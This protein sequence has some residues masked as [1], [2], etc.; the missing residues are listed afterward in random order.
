MICEI[1]LKF[2]Y[3]VEN[4]C[5]LKQQGGQIWRGGGSVPP[6][7]IYIYSRSDSSVVERSRLGPR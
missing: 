1:Q 3:C 6:S 2:P 4:V 5:F 7:D